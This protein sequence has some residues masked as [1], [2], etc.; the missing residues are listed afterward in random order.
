MYFGAEDFRFLIS[1]AFAVMFARFIMYLTESTQHY[2]DEHYP[3]LQY[4]FIIFY[5]VWYVMTLVIFVAY[6]WLNPTLKADPV[7]SAFAILLCVATSGFSIM[8]LLDR[9]L[10]VRIKDGR[11]ISQVFP[12]LIVIVLILFPYTFADAWGRFAGMVAKDSQPLVE[13]YAQYQIIDDIQWEST[14]TNSFRTT[15]DLRLVFSN[16]QYI[17]LG[18]VTDRNSLYV[19]AI[20]DILSVKIVGSE[21]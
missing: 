15:D 11:I 3:R 9:K 4:G 2:Y 8:V 16:Q 6:M 13:L 12:W 5:L 1:L 10:L 17:V 19:V 14:N 7:Y 18:P 20:D 21:E